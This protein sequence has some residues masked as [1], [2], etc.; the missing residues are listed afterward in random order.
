MENDVE[1]A[2]RKREP[3]HRTVAATLRRR[4]R[5]GEWETDSL[6]PSEDALAGELMVGRSTIREALRGLEQEGLIIR[7]QG[8]GSFVSPHA[9]RINGNLSALESFIDTIQQSGHVA[10]VETIDVQVRQAGKGVHSHLRLEPDDD[11]WQVRNIYYADDVPA[12]YTQALIPVSVVPVT[13]D[14]ARSLRNMPVRVFLSSHSK[15]QVESA[16]LN[17]EARKADDVVAGA[18][19]LRRGDALLVLSGTALDTAGAPAYFMSAHIN[20]NVYQF[21]VLRR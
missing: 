3:L 6:L 15:I 21:T 2:Y 18:M 13:A 12:I 19:D 9:T 1:I 5:I 16:V 14:V 8:V 4:I 10:R 11:V 20:T 17:V 7:R